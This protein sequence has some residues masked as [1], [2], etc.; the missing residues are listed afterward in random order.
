MKV[1]VI[2]AKGLPPKQGGI[3]HYCAEVY[4]RMAAQGHSIDVFARASYTEL[5]WFYR[6]NHQGV[7][8]ITLPSLRFRGLDALANAA[9]GSTLTLLSQYDVVHFHALGPAL[10]SLVPRLKRQTKVVVS[11]QGLDWQRNKW[12]HWPRRIIRLG[13]F[14]AVQCAHRLIVVS[15]ALQSYFLDTYGRDTVYIPNAPAAYA[16]SDPQFG[17]AQSLGLHPGKYI[18]FVGR[19]VPEKCPDLLIQAF[20]RLNPPGWKL[21]LVGGS[22]D[23]LGFYRQLQQWSKH[24]PD[25]LL[26]GELRGSRLAEL[27]R[28]AGLFVLPSDV[29]G[30][31]LAMLEAMQEGIPIVASDIPPHRQLL[32]EGQGVLFE[33]ASLADC[34]KALDW[35]IQNPADMQAMAALAQQHVRDQYTW[36]QITNRTLDLYT[37]LLRSRLP[38]QARISREVG[39]Y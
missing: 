39:F 38:R 21:V 26:T 34:M 3:E 12:G 28:G 16:A 9:I 1:A 35:A 37:T 4:P 23:T 2:G 5:P 29:E 19:L 30:L 27:V 6:Y 11:C 32:G 10:C 17:Y 31:P 13:E 33:K 7:Q 36:D 24:N 22:S 8:V 18:V 20:H 25:I 15:E 14:T